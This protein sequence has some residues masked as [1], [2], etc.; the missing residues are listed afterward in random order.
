MVATCAQLSNNLTTGE[1]ASFN[2]DIDPSG[3]AL[4]LFSA[5]SGP[6]WTFGHWL[7]S[8]NQ[9]QWVNGNPLDESKLCNPAP[10]GT[11]TT[12]IVLNGNCWSGA[13]WDIQMAGI[14]RI[15]PLLSSTPRERE[16]VAP[17]PPAI[18]RSASET[19]D[20]GSYRFR[21]SS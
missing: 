16:A 3:E 20:D 21:Y 1:L 7:E 5:S 18:L 4:S 12:G 8:A 13:D 6:F 2:Q 15:V 17:R 19:H 9:W 10:T 14:C 11:S